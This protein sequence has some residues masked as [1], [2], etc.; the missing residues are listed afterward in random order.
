MTSATI[1]LTGKSLCDFVDE[2]TPLIMR[3]EL[4]RTDMIKDAGYVYDNGKAMYVDFYTEL[5]NSRN[6]LNPNYVAE[7]DAADAEYEALSGVEQ[8]L[9]DAVNERFGEKW[10]HEEI[11]EFMSELDD[12]GIDTPEALD[13]SV[14]WQTD[15]YNPEEK[16]AEY[17][18]TEAMCESIPSLVEGC[19]DWQT[20]WQSS[21][22][23]DYNV[24]EFDGEAYF[25][26]NI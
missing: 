12:I 3:G 1:M 24:I 2:K 14:E 16:F 26:R 17:F 9:Y 22:R 25:F 6:I 8:D 20:V 7:R 21:L 11:V 18:V 4:T 19:I 23:Y 10:S 5:L 15:E 13:E